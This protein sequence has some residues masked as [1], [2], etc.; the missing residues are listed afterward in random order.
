METEKKKTVRNM[1]LRTAKRP[2]GCLAIS[3]DWDAGEAHYQFSVQNPKDKFDAVIGKEIATGR[4]A[5]SPRIITVSTES[6][7]HEITKAVMMDLL[8]NP[9][10]PKRA[11]RAAQDWI[12]EKYIPH[13][14]H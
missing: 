10:T 4:L 5:K 13:T 1:Y 12:I 7:C 9:Q 6:N 8:A 14:A 2:V 11:V 3:V